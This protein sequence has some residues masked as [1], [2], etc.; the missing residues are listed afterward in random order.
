M[1][2][3]IRSIKKAFPKFGWYRDG[4]GYIRGSY[5]SN[6]VSLYM[7]V[8]LVGDQYVVESEFSDG[9]IRF[10]TPPLAV[11]VES[12]GVGVNRIMT[13]SLAN[14]KD[15]LLDVVLTIHESCK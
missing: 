4:C 12:G 14:L 10:Q 9:R 3:D 6:A 15:K 13:L 2:L 7:C 8:S 1:R 5:R 11:N